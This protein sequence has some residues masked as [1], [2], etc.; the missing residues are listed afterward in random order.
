MVEPSSSL[1]C[2]PQPTQSMYEWA[3]TEYSGGNMY[4]EV[5]GLPINKFTGSQID[6]HLEVGIQ[7]WTRTGQ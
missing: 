4:E 3:L 1:L 6:Q 7:F 2:A 5:A